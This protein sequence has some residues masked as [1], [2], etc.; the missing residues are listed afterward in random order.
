MTT[1][2]KLKKELKIFTAGLII[3]PM[4]LL[5]VFIFNGDKAYSFLIF[6]AIFFIIFAIGFF[7]TKKAIK[8]YSE[9]V[10]KSQENFGE[11]D[12]NFRV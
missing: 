6:F 10:E 7:K 12:E 5:M 9:L 2:Q 11:R 1:I 8:A 4:L 3:L